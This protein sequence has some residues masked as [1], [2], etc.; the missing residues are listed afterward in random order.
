MSLSVIP[1]A[2]CV[3]VVIIT[4]L[5]SADVVKIKSG[6]GS[7]VDPW[8][9]ATSADQ[10]CSGGTVGLFIADVVGGVVQ[11]CGNHSISFIHHL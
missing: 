2:S 5:Y 1:P 9:G 3:V 10:Q 8:Y 6:H 7:T 4:R 11:G